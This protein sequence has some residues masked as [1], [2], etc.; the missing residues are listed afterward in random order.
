MNRV[1]SF[2][3]KY[4]AV[5]QKWIIIFFIWIFLVLIWSCNGDTTEEFPDCGCYQTEYRKV[6]AGATTWIDERISGKAVTCDTP[7]G[8]VQRSTYYFYVVKCR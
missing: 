6:R 5:I 1:L 4:R 3:E 2:L 7:E 8:R